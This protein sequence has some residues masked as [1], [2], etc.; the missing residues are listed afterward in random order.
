MSETESLARRM[1]ADRAQRRAA[2]RKVII[3]WWVGAALFVAAIVG[4]RQAYHWAKAR[5]A[6]QFAEAGNQLAAAGK[7]EEAASKFRA[8]LQLDPM[9]YR[10]L[11]G[12]AVLASRL[13]R[14][15]AVGLWEEVIKLPEATT[16][17]RQGYAESLVTQGRFKIAEPVITALLKGNPDTRTL[18]IASRYSRA[19]GDS[20]KAI[21]FAR[22]AVKRAPADE[23]ARAALADLLAASTDPAERA[24]ARKILWELAEKEGPYRVP[25]LE[26]LATAPELSAEE[27]AR[28]LQMLDASPAP[29]IKDALLASDLRLQL[30]PADA[31]KIFDQ[32][33]ARWNASKN[34]DLNQLA[35]WLNLR[36]QPERVLSLF[37]VDRAFQDNRLLLSRLDALAALQRWDEIDRLLGHPD[38]TLDPSVLESFRARAAQEKNATMDAA[39]HW[40]HALSLAANDAFK[41]RF[42]A[43]FAEQSH[44]DAVALKA[45]ELLGKIPD[46]GVAAFRETQRLSANTADASVQ[47]AAAEKIAALA[48][49]DPNT[50]AQLAYLNLLVGTDVDTNFQKAKA[51]AEKYPDRLSYRVTAALGYLRKHDPGPALA[52]FKGPPGAPPIDWPKTPPGWRAVYA[53]TLLANE[54]AG[55]AEEIIKTIP[56]DQLSPQERALIEPAK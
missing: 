12:A 15:E 40:S 7:F 47:R 35:L 8:A 37:S 48:Q 25:A 21:E 29:Q 4:G 28:V 41:L 19:T 2:R 23:A 33:V 42:V 31:D 14:P 32:T 43:R 17:D 26:G 55:A 52:Q 51:L 10:P 34:P 44:A 38:L 50:A 56:R 49:N 5:R 16:G 9:G 22:V 13:N 27:R 24:E 39:V 18:I 11:R 45:F 1:A 46:Q 20:P 3:A 36:G 53:A 30:H 6:G 54:E